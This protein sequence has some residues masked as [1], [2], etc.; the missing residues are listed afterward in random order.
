MSTALVDKTHPV[1]VRIPMSKL[2]LSF[3]VLFMLGAI[4]V[5]GAIGFATNNVYFAFLMFGLSLSVF[6]VF[7]IFDGPPESSTRP[8]GGPHGVVL[9]I[10]ALVAS[11]VGASVLAIALGHASRYLI[12]TRGGEGEKIALAGL[13]IGYSSLFIQGAIA[14]WFITNLFQLATLAGG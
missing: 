8:S 6:F 7:A 1:G 4:V 5:G 10:L 3:F 11:C 9:P 12:K 13:I 2:S 14:L